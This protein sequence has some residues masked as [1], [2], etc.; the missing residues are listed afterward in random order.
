MKFRWN[1]S[2]CAATEGWSVFKL[3]ME[4][5]VY[6][7]E[8]RTRQ[9]LNPLAGSQKFTWFFKLIIQSRLF[10]CCSVQLGELYRISYDDE[11]NRREQPDETNRMGRDLY[12]DLPPVSFLPP[13]S[14]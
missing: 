10:W 11:T 2:F 1:N 5:I 14:F 12:R 9:P 13:K 7:D 4:R 6:T 3:K 8:C